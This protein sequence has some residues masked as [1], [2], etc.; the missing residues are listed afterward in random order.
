MKGL[1]MTKTEETVKLE[2]V[3]CVS[4]TLRLKLKDVRVEIGNCHKAAKEESLR[5]GRAIDRI[6]RVGLEICEPA[7]ARLE[8]ME[9]FAERAEEKRK[10]E[11]FE[12]R[13]EIVRQYGDPGFY[14]LG[15]MTEGQFNALIEG[16]ELEANRK[17]LAEAKL[18]ADLANQKAHD[19][20]VAA[21]AKAEAAQ[22]EI[23]AKLEAAQSKLDA[24]R[25]A[26][27]EALA[28]QKAASN[29]PVAL[30]TEWYNLH[31]EPCRVDHEGLCQTHFLQ[32]DCIVKRTKELLSRIGT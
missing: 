10:A 11:L 14:K 23:Q 2:I 31:P 3:Q 20:R 19:E 8:E 17:Y 21:E 29:T 5:T 6:K 26:A 22:R 15:D 32:R 16:F 13:A 9:K 12:K 25:K 27:Q 7:E 18:S 1:Q 28:K 4:E 24:E 30:L